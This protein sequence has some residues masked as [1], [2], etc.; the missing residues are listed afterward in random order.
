M[1][2]FPADN[3]SGFASQPASAESGKIVYCFTLMR[4]TS[5]R[6]ASMR[7]S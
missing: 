4:L 5:V 7:M 6:N 1:G 2:D 3:A